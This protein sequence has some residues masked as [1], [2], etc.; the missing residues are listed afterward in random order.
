[1]GGEMNGGADGISHSGKSYGLA[2]PTLWVRIEVLTAT[3]VST[4]VSI[5]LV[6]L[7]EGGN[8]ARRSGCSDVE[9]VWFGS[10]VVGGTV[11]DCG[12]RSSLGRSEGCACDCACSWRSVSDGLCLRVRCGGLGFSSGRGGR[13][14]RVR[15]VL[16]LAIG[17]VDLLVL[18]LL[19]FMGVGS[20]EALPMPASLSAMERLYMFRSLPSVACICRL[21]YSRLASCRSVLELG[22]WASSLAS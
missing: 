17:S 20:I 15:G 6:R 13:A 19:P 4:V 5:V 1:V 10:F 12:C 11:E 21:L 3:V 2:N 16:L 18:D 22:A 14:L 7:K 9:N 8:L